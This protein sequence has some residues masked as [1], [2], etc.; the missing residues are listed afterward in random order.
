LR[1]A[2]K[3]RKAYRRHCHFAKVSREN[4]GRQEPNIEQEER[5]RLVASVSSTLGL[6][7]ENRSLLVGNT[8]QAE[9]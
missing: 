2:R 5:Y 7:P 8:L 3:L 1:G 9:Y 6:L 4:V